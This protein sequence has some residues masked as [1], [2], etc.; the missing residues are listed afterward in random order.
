[1]AFKVLIYAQDTLGLGHVRRC[2]TIAR[3]LLAGRADASVLLATK[4]SWPARESLGER[5]DFLK[6]PS[7]FTLAG[8]SAA[9]HDGEREAIRDLRRDLLRDAAA[10]LRPHLV[11]VDNEPLGFNGEM[12]Q[13]LAAADG[14]KAVFGMRDVLDDPAR[15]AQSW[16]QLDVVG[17]LRDRFD[18][19]LVYGHEEL[20]DTLGTYDVPADVAA[21]ARY[22]GY[23]VARPPAIDVAAVRARL[24]CGERPVVLVTGGGGQDAARLCATAL[25]ALELMTSHP[26]P[27]GLVVTGPFMPEDDRA[28][29]AER[30]GR[31]GH[32]LVERADL[33]EA[34]AA[35]DAVVTMGGYNT[36]AETMLFGKRP[37]VV[38]RATHKR[39]QLMRA[40]AFE[41]HGLV[42][43]LPPEAASPQAMAAALE[44]E[45]R[46]PAAVDAA[47][48]LD[49]GALRTAQLLLER[50]FA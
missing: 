50:A 36:L 43:C 13:A 9:E 24:A 48:F 17:S 19:V 45:L 4:S 5:F 29:L 3:A 34:M 11:L 47:R 20:F 49:V 30:A 41:Q 46:A 1:M 44:A 28:A 7:Q 38:P 42:R 6:L 27:R 35:A 12:V 21:R 2:T 25:A 8:A 15:T 40:L 22:T 10:R 23:V 16:A 26:R 32:V 31:G 37:I 18:G 39:E 14:A 33:A